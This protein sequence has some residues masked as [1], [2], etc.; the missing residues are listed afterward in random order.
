VLLR[1]FL[2]LREVECAE[3]F[4]GFVALVDDWL[5]CAEAV[6]KARSTTHPA[7]KHVVEMELHIL[8]ICPEVT[9]TSTLDNS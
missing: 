7:L 2:L 5:V 1:D 9:L 3:I 8:K 4:F 6:P